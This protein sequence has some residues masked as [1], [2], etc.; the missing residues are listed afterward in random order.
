MNHSLDPKKNYLFNLNHLGILDLLGPSSRE[1]LQGQISC[2][3]REV[4]TSQMRQGA[5]CNLKGRVLALMDVVDHEGLKVILPAALHESTQASLNKPAALSRVLIKKDETY[6]VYGFYLQ[7]NEDIC[8]FDKKKETERYDVIPLEGGCVY[9]RGH[10]LFIVILDKAKRDAFVAPFIKN[11]Q[12]LD[13]HPWHIQ[14]LRVGQFEIYPE[15]RGLF[16][17]HRLGLHESGHLSFNKGCYKGQEII[18][19]MHYRSTLK[20]TLKIMERETTDMLAPGQP[21]FS[22]DKQTQLGEIIDVAPMEEH[23]VIVVASV[24]I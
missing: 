1:F 5:L 9:S 13:R 17:P 18:A 15:T 23:H 19:R 7:N 4:S 2:D 16:L 24:L 10:N 21:L 12:W 22:E 11:N 14:S 6:D 20:H 3:V 8:I